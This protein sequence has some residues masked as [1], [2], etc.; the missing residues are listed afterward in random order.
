M[1]V[2][3]YNGEPAMNL[4]MI[5]FNQFGKLINGNGGHAKLFTDSAVFNY[6]TLFSLKQTTTKRPHR[7]GSLKLTLIL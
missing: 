2:P 3:I 7:P 6:C 4:F 1:G 5:E